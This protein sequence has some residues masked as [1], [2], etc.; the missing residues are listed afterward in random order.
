MNRANRRGSAA[1]VP[2]G[3]LKLS[4]GEGHHDGGEENS[5]KLHG[6]GSIDCSN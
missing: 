1:Y 2:V 6:V 4:R 5:S 3:A